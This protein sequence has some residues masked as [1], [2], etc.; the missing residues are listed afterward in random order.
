MSRTIQ[1]SEQES[2]S[3]LARAIHA[4]LT[5]GS[6]AGSSRWPVGVV[7][8]GMTALAAADS[9]P[10]AQLELSSLL[11]THGGDGSAGF[12]MSGVARYDYTGYA[13]SGPETSMLTA[14]TT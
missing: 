2:P 3:R 7:L 5:R 4:A 11:P 12:V 8:G 1:P 9:S 13:V 6:R 14:S 10:L